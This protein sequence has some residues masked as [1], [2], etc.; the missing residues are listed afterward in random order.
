MLWFFFTDHNA[1]RDAW[2]NLEM[3]FAHILLIGGYSVVH[4]QIYDK[5]ISRFTDIR[6]FLLPN[7]GI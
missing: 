3:V 2:N 5:N 6:I 1:L 4:L 7:I